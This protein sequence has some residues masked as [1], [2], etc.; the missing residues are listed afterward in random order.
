[1]RRAHR[2]S[3]SPAL[4]LIA[5]L[6]GAPASL[7]A[8]FG[9]KEL[10]TVIPT[11]SF[12]A[13][14]TNFTYFNEGFTYYQVISG[15]PANFFASTELPVGSKVNQVCALVRDDDAAAEVSMDFA[16]I[17]LQGNPGPSLTALGNVGSGGAATPHY[18]TICVTPPANTTI[19]AFADADGDLT[20]HYLSYRISVSLKA[21]NNLAFGGA[22]LKW[23]RQQAPA[24]AVATF[25]DVPTDFL[26]FRAIENLAAAG[27]TG[28]CSPGNYCPNAN[29]TRGEAAAFFSK[30]LG[31]NWPQ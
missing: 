12:A 10:T 29:I 14:S 22:V 19:R 6:L 25:A 7:H 15:N 8:Q 13:G 23:Q 26:F 20:S 31:L 11:S 17:E 4:C 18:T 28:G 16:V 2:S 1:M 5:L 30:A 21:S 3:A 24:P 27:I 9:T